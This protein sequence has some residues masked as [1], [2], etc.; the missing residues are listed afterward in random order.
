M[1]CSRHDARSA[2]IPTKDKCFHV[3]QGLNTELL[4]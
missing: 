3:M 4:F 2:S 1:T